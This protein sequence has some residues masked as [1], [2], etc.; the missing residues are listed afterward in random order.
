M[1]V[2][3]A[4]VSTSEQN[5]DLQVQSLKSAGCERVFT[6]IV[7]GAKAER[8]GLKEMNEY[9]REGDTVVV[10]KLDRLGRSLS[11]LVEQINEYE[12]KKVCFQSLTENIDTT[13]PSGKLFFHVF[14]ALAEFERELIRERTRAGLSAAKIK[15]REGGRPRKLNKK[16]IEMMT[17]MWRNQNYKVDDICSTFGISRT[18]FYRNIKELAEDEQRKETNY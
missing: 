14:G 8:L 2:G 12:E 5:L 9:V 17:D 3:Y 6:D 11:H 1:K 4:R 15:G 18:T 16:Q 13:T 7:S 10:W